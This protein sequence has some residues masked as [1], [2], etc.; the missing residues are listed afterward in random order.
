MVLEILSQ[1]VLALTLNRCNAQFPELSLDLP[2]V[3]VQGNS[4]VAI[5]VACTLQT[6]IRL[7]YGVCQIRN[8]YEY[9]YVSSVSDIFW[10]S[11]WRT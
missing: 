1:F 5:E 9:E 3:G 6:P 7:K 10:M 2:L 8:D 11:W 4:K